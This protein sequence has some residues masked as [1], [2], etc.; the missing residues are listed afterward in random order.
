MAKVSVGMWSTT[1]LFQRVS[2]TML[3]L[4]KGWEQKK[5]KKD[6]N[7]YKVRERNTRVSNQNTNFTII[8]ASPSCPAIRTSLA[9][10]SFRGAW[11]S[12]QLPGEDE[13][14]PH[15]PT[16]SH[17]HPL[18]VFFGVFFE[19]GRCTKARSSIMTPWLWRTSST[20]AALSGLL[21]NKTP[22][23]VARRVE[24]RFELQTD[25][26]GEAVPGINVNYYYLHV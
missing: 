9:E 11:K 1:A 23:F 10:A 14:P 15:H 7:G 2:A 19:A 5:K 18:L 17:H 24:E 21:C 4:I 16:P 20:P 3:H 25:S 8:S 13:D 12:S 6:G 26:A 22:G